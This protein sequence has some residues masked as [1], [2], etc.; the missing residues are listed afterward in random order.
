[1]ITLNGKPAADEQVINDGDS[2]QI[3]GLGTLKDLAVNLEL[4][5]PPPVMMINEKP[6]ALSCK[7]NPGDRVDWIENVEGA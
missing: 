3:K 1:M 7:V 6:A 5:Q 2:V 4:K